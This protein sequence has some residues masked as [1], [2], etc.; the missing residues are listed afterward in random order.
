[1][2]PDQ[3]RN[4]P[5][6]LK[7][8][9]PAPAALTPGLIHQLDQLRSTDGLAAALHG[10]HLHQIGTGFIRDNLGEVRRFEYPAPQDETGYF[11]V[12]FNPARARRFSGRGLTTPPAGQRAINNGCFL[13]ADN[14]AWQQQGSEQGYPLRLGHRD[15]IAW[16]NPFPL[17]ACHAIVATRDHLPQHWNDAEGGLQQLLGELLELASRLPG[18]ISFYNGVGAGASIEGHLHY[19]ALPRTSGLKPLPIELAA[20][21]QALNAEPGHEPTLVQGVYPIE[22]AHWRGPVDEVLERAAH[23]LSNWQQRHPNE[24]DA[25]ANLMACQATESPLLD[26]YFVPRVRSR[27]RA[28]G[29]GGVIGAFETMGE[30]ICSSDEELALI[31]SGQIDY[32]RLAAMLSQVSVRL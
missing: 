25:T 21:R 28:E 18:W 22:F 13:C 15:F 20:D 5:H 29:L 11:S 24:Q 16:M 30:I 1:M 31:E 32:S 12:Q 27:S 4:K 6:P 7:P 8:D 10:L 9:D 23:W 17:A 26:L 3:P 14:I 2:K 19:H